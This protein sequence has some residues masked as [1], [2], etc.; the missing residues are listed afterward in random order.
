M[1]T[2]EYQLMYQAEEHHW[3]Y[4]ALHELILRFVAAEAA[5]RGPLTIFDAGCGT[6][7]LCQLMQPFGNVSGCD[8]SEQAIELA[9]QRGLEGIS[10][11]DLNHLVLE[12]RH[13]D[14]IT[15]IDVLYHRWVTDDIAVLARLHDALK[16]G[17]I[18]ILNLV[19]WP[20]LYSDHDV[21]V[22]TRERYTRPV[23]RER[24]HAAGFTSAQLTYRVSLLFPPI[25]LYRLLT[26]R[27]DQTA[28]TGDVSSDVH[29]PPAWVNRVLLHLMRAE[30]SLLAR[31]SLPIGTSLF[32]VARR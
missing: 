18:L 4:R 21:A 23:L 25:A 20:F 8:L 31:Y 12:S 22:H 5:R 2:R 15:S 1:N 19:A 28:V 13:Y 7:R 3:W 27:P 6:G 14:L 26:R 32:A 9:R 17:G 29:L 24:L 11:Q 10:R 16:P 30:N